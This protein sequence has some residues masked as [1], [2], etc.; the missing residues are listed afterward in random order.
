MRGSSIAIGVLA[1]HLAVLASLA[2]SAQVGESNT[3]EQNCH[4]QKTLC[5]DACGAHA[6]P[7]ECEARCHDSLTDCLRECR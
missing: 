4:E 6:N 7:V 5:I 1:V 3:C 2:I